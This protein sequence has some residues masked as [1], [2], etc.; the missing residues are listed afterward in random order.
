M[1][2]LLWVLLA[3][4]GIL[5]AL[6]LWLGVRL[7]A[8]R[9]AAQQESLDRVEAEAARA[10]SEMLLSQI[11]AE[12]ASL[13]QAVSQHTARQTALQGDLASLREIAEHHRLHMEEAEQAVAE[14]NRTKSLFVANMSHEL[15]TPLNGILGLTRS[16]LDSNLNSRQQSEVELIQLAGEDLIRIVNDILDFSKLEASKLTLEKIPFH[17]GE[18]LEGVFSLLYPQAARKHLCYALTYSP[19][20]RMRYLG[21]PFRIR[22]IVLNLLSNAIKFTQSGHVFVHAEEIS[23]EADCSRIQLVFE[24]SGIGISSEKQRLIFDDFQQADLSTTRRFGGTG[25]GLSL[26]RRVVELMGGEIHVESEAGTGS[27]FRVCLPLHPIV[28]LEDSGSLPQPARPAGL[29]G[30]RLLVQQRHSPES[31]ALQRLLE[32]MPGLEILPFEQASELSGIL[33]STDPAPVDAIVSSTSALTVWDDETVRFLLRMG[34]SAP[35]LIVLRDQH[36]AVGTGRHPSLETVDLETPVLPS[37]LLGLL[38]KLRHAP[39]GPLFEAAG[40]TAF[41]LFRESPPPRLRNG[42]LLL[43]NDNPVELLRLEGIARKLGM[44]WRS[45][46]ST[47]E[48]AQAIASE[49]VSTAIVQS[50]LLTTEAQVAFWR[51]ASED[52]PPVRLLV[53]G[54]LDAALRAQLG[55]SPVSFQALPES[56]RLAQ[57]R[58]AL[59]AT[60]SLGG[61]SSSNFQSG[62]SRESYFSEG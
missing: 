25:L 57:L 56:P 58:E 16:L 18:L 59:S 27:T 30:I 43:A 10:K 32:S 62:D 34:A 55:T 38:K 15:R 14:A 11:Q 12:H 21:D 54:A 19:S 51:T 39:L 37:H 41:D 7:R 6:S 2:A 23:S 40:M 53:T 9:Q 48:L 46:T 44:E 3:V 5:L 1:T 42:I 29:D 4:V 8:S 60:T 61:S 24:D 50:S 22:Q 36:E 52:R 33:K 47:K 17:L 28:L 31:V 49:T 35:P 13:A 20:M 45:T 26:S